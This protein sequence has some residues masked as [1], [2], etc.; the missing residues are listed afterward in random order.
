MDTRNDRQAV[1]AYL[2][3]SRLMVRMSVGA[4]INGIIQP[5]YIV[6]HE[7]APRVVQ[8]IVGNF[9]HVSLTREGLLIPLTP[10]VTQ[11]A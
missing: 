2:M 3:N 1:F 8:E 6:I 11:E 4:V 10:L 9:R 5:D 7:A